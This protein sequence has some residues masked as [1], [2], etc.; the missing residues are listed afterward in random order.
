MGKQDAQET[1]RT[2]SA[3]F[4]RMTLSHF[5]PDS[6]HI[7]H[8]Q[9]KKKSNVKRFELSAGIQ[10]P[11]ITNIIKKISLKWADPG[12]GANVFV[13]CFSSPLF[14]RFPSKSD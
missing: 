14:L 8:E 12:G 7:E 5:Q 4:L 13:F 10:S 9:N 6:D 2:R 3:S 11:N 1:P